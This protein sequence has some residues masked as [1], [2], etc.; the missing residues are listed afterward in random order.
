MSSLATFKGGC[1]CGAVRFEADAE[2]K[3]ELLD[4]DCSICSM[5]GYLHLIVPRRSFR[6]LAGEESL[7]E[8]RFGTGTA[9]HLFCRVCGVKSF[10]VPRCDPEGV[11]VNWR[12]L[13]NVEGRLPTVRPFYGR[14][15]RWLAEARI[16]RESVDVSSDPA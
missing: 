13:E 1:H 11:S 4:C 5:T 7:K 6:L 16:A 2:Q 9:R 10:Y 8:Y 3:P 14:V 15:G 12:A